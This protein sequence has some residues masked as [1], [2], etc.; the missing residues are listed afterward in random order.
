MLPAKDEAVG[1]GRTLRSILQAGLLP[2]DVYV[3]DD[4]SSDKTLEVARSAFARE[5]HAG[6]V[7]ILTKPNSGKADA[8][9]LGLEHLR[10]EEVFV[11]IDADTLVAKD[12]I[13][14]LV[15]HFLNPKVGA[16]HHWGP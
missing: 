16:V 3:I 5:E 2:A 11:G 4:G 15:P 6:K 1:I 13:S 8:L 12:A 10:D 7:L 9:N 14:R